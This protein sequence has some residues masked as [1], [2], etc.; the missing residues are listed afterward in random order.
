M[1]RR[2]SS[3]D[4][5]LGVIVILVIIAL[6]FKVLAAIAIICAIG[7]LIYLL[8]LLGKYIYTRTKESNEKNFVA[9]KET[10]VTEKRDT[11]S[12]R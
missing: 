2:S 11:T 4:G 1:S 5:F 12:I 8:F 10:V 6:L 9:R 7:F 3:D